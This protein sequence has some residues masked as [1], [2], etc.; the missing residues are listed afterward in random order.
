[1]TTTYPFRILFFGPDGWITEVSTMLWVPTRYLTAGESDVEPVS[2][3][4]AI[5]ESSLVEWRQHF[6]DPP[7][8]WLICLGEGL[9]TLCRKLRMTLECLHTRTTR[10]HTIFSSPI[11]GSRQGLLLF[12][13]TLNRQVARWACSIINTMMSAATPPMGF[14]HL[15]HFHLCFASSHAA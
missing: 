12:L 3:V 2:G 5:W 6:S 8:S 7:S 15:L 1:M 11:Q 9:A 14:Q 13:C 4:G 10:H